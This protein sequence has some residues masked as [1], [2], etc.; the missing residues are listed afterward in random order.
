VPITQRNF[1]RD[2]DSLAMVFDLIDKFT[3]DKRVDDHSK[4]A[5][6]VAVDELFTNMVKY[7]PSNR[8]PITVELRA[9]RGTMTV[10]LIDRDVDRFDPTK[11]PAPYLGSSL[12]ERTPTG[13]G[14]FLTKQLM[15]DVQYRYGDRTSLIILKK[16]YQRQN[17]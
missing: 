8:Y 12:I 1:S 16:R 10:H 11:Q 6:S 3:A 17:V 15:D 13:L 2:L 14:I 7:Q 5:V 9:D 4:H